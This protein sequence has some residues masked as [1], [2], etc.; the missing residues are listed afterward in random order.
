MKVLYKNLP[1]TPGVYLMK[2]SGG[3]VLYV[4]KAGNLK[5]RV[6]S[7]FIKGQELRI[8]KLL[9][10][11]E[12]IN[13]KKTD[14]AVEALILEA[15]LIKKYSPPFNVKEKDDKSFLYVGIT[16]D[17]FPRV[18]LLRAKEKDKAGVDRLFGPFTSASNIREALR[19]IRRIFPYSVHNANLRMTMNWA[20]KKI[21]RPCFDYQ[22]GLCPG[23]CI[24][25]ISRKDYLRTI[26]NIKLIFSGKKK[27]ILKNLKKEMNL[28]SENMEYEK[29]AKIRRQIFA[30]EHIRDVALITED[31]LKP[32]TYNLKP[33]YRIEGYDISNISG[34]S[35]VG[36]MVVFEKGKPNK[37]EYR[38][39]RIRTLT[40][41]NDVGMLKEVL[42]RRFNNNWPLP[43]LILVDGGKGQVNAVKE[44]ISELN[45][46]IQVLGIAKGPK[47]KRNDFYGEIPRGIDKDILVKV[48]DE[49]HRFAISYH[50][51]LRAK[52][53]R[54]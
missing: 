50:K 5:R 46:A 30:L 37:A 1:E 23:T 10:K 22:I 2:D 49:A 3:K 17:L 35:A 44:V 32:K 12:K 19:I 15:K 42:R 52:G 7:Y 28:A 20:D 43:D 31:E 8:E 34:D 53:F 38:R 39:F 47:R 6:S 14:T 48:R 4:G 16:K 45:L 11:V 33:S 25:A 29:A 24:G 41:P 51:K 27:E 21:A 9:E 18:L 36:S 13:Y 54:E 26:K 40:S